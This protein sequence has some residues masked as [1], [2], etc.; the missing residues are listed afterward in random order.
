MYVKNYYEAIEKAVASQGRQSDFTYTTGT[1]ED[2]DT[3]WH[4]DVRTDG[5]FLTIYTSP[6]ALVR[7]CFQTD[8]EQDFDGDV[9]TWIYLNQDRYPYIPLPPDFFGS[10]EEDEWEEAAFLS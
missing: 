1:G 8:W 2:V 9:E 10:A 4:V 6:D 5:N 7:G 3:I